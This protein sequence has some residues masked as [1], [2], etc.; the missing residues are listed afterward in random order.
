MRAVGGNWRPH[1]ELT[2]RWYP[3]NKQKVTAL[4]DT[5]AEY[6]LIPG[7]LQEFSGPFSAIDGFQG[8]LVK[9]RKVPLTLQI[10]C[11]PAQEYEDFISPIPENILGTD[12]LQGQTLQTSVGEFCLHVRVIKPVLLRGNANWESVSLPFPLMKSGNCQG[13]R[14]N[15]PRTALSGYSTPC[16]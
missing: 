12:I 6:T 10:G 3:R 13:N 8:Q 5:W 1:V 16:P 11:S 7:K 4:I 2:I 9:V 15:Y 14:R